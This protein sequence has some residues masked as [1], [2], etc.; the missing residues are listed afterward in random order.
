MNCPYC[1]NEMKEGKV[2]ST[3]SGF[4]S[5][6]H[7]FLT[8]EEAQKGFMELVK[9]V[10]QGIRF[11]FAVEYGIR[12]QDSEEAYYCEQCGKVFAEYDLPDIE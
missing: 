8:E 10:V 7:V 6:Q 1:Q 2:N 9:D 5:V 3:A 12:L 4:D 11:G